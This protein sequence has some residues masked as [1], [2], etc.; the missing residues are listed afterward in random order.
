MKLVYSLIIS[1]LF[2]GTA[3]AQWTAL[4]KLDHEVMDIYFLDETTGF[5]VT[6]LD[7]NGNDHGQ[8]MKTTDG[9]SSWTQKQ[10]STNNYFSA[11]QFPNNGSTGYALENGGDFYKTTDMG[12]SWTNIGEASAS[13]NETMYWTSADEGYYSDASITWKTTDGGSNWVEKQEFVTGFQAL[14]FFGNQGW[15]YNRTNFYSSSDAG[16]TWSSSVNLPVVIMDMDFVDS[17]HGLAVGREDK[18][19]LSEDG[20]ATWTSVGLNDRNFDLMAV[21]FLSNKVTFAVGT[22]DDP[23]DKE[24][25]TVMSVDS[26]K[27]WTVV[28]NSAQANLNDVFFPNTA[29]GF[30]GGAEG[31]FMKLIPITVGE[32][33]IKLGDFKVFPNPFSESIFLEFNSEDEKAASYQ[34]LDLSGRRVKSAS[35]VALVEQIDLSDLE[36]STYILELEFK[37]KKEIRRLIKR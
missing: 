37:D 9:G 11:I 10:Y 15:Y 29:I 13:F 14:E 22:N 18:I 30:T 34:I 20:G 36:S 25:R 12:E 27:T 5:A 16:A 4:P 32:A 1:I 19:Y 35:A 33:E 28:N 6:M 7:S 31:E 24:P 17:D 26:G 21:K 8:I 23:F 3:Y 2:S